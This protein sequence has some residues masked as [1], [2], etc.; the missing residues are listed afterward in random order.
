MEKIIQSPQTQKKLSS[1]WPI[2]ERINLVYIQ[3]ALIN[4][5][6]WSEEDA[7]LCHKY[8]KQYLYLKKEYGTKYAL[9][10]SLAIDEFW[11]L[12]IMDTIAYTD[13]C[14]SIFGYYLHHTPNYSPNNVP[15]DVNEEFK[16]TAT[17]FSEVFNEKL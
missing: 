17:L 10:P 2:I 14:M 12:H 11:H 13:H 7:S 16:V 1:C 9:P 5:K 3:K 8:Y 6:G 15:M 4:D